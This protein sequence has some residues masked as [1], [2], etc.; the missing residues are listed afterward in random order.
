MNPF[1]LIKFIKLIYIGIADISKSVLTFVDQIASGKKVP[2]CV[3]EQFPANL[4]FKTM[5]LDKYANP[6]TADLIAVWTEHTYDSE[7]I[8][9]GP[10]RG[11]AMEIQKGQG[12]EITFFLLFPLFFLF[13]KLQNI[14]K[15]NFSSD[16]PFSEV[17]LILFDY[18]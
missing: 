13:F 18:L 10:P 6:T 3:V 8:L 17:L 4:E 15:E 16:P 11:Q 1:Y 7:E 9:K 2:Y 12:G 14:L 5:I